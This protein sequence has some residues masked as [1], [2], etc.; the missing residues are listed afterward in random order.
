MSLDQEG[1]FMPKRAAV[2]VAMLAGRLGDGAVADERRPPGAPL[3][4]L[5]E[6]DNTRQ[7]RP[8]AVAVGLKPVQPPV[9][10][11]IFDDGLA[12]SGLPGP[13]GA[14]LTAEPP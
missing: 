10:F 1:F 8:I 5:S 12:W 6:G 11:V 2:D 13:K 3:R 4:G 7:P 14:G 9:P